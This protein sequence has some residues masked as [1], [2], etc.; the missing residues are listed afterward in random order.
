MNKTRLISITL[1]GFLL[2][3]CGGKEEKKE[4]ET[5][6]KDSVVAEEPKEPAHEYTYQV[7]EVDVPARW[8]LS[9]GDSTNVSD[10]ATFFPKNM[11]MVGKTAGLKPKDI[12]EAPIGIY[13]NFAID[14]KFFTKAG[15]VVSDSTLKV[16]APGKLEKLPAMKAVKV[17]YMGDYMGMEKAYGDLMAYVK[18]KGYEPLNIQWEQYVTD[19]GREKDTTKW[20]TD[21]Y[22]GIK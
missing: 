15:L 1:L 21:I 13:Y 7:S 5:P 22:Y 8:F 16:K 14:K 4:E 20:Q 11:P 12:K 6:K 17:V 19:P 10:L 2:V 3:N 18:E 9:I